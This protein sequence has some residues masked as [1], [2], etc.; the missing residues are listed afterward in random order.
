MR[1]FSCA[2]VAICIIASSASRAD[3]TLR[4]IVLKADVV[5]YYSNRYILT[6]DGHV[7]ARLSDGTVVSGETFAMDLKLNRFIIAG[8]VRLDGPTVH[9]TG[10]AFSG[11]PDLDRFYFLPEGEEPDRWTFFGSDYK[12]THAGR[13]QPGDAFYFPNLDNAAPYLVGD[14]VTIFPKNNIEFGPG[15]RIRIAGVYTP[16]PGWVVNFSSNPNFYQNGFAGAVFDIQVPFRGSANDITAFDIRYDQYQGAFL[17]FEEHLVHNADYLVFTINPLTQD[18]R[19]WNLIAYK[20]ISPAIETRLFTQLSTLSTWPFKEPSQS[21]AYTNFQINSRIGKYAASLN[22]DQYNNSL[23]ETDNSAY[24]AQ[25][26]QVDGHPFDVEFNLQSFEDEW[27]LFRSLGVPLKFQYRAGYGWDYNGYGILAVNGEPTW[28]GALYPLIANTYVG[29]TVYTPSIR[30]ARLTTFSVK[31]DKERQWFSLPHHID[32]TNTTATLAYTPTVSKR[33]AF[34]ASYNVLNI[35]DYYGADQLEAY[36]PGG[37]GCLGAPAPNTCNTITNQY[38]TYTGLDAFRGIATSRGLTGSVIYTP[39]RYVAVNLTMQHFDVSPAPVPG[40]G[41]QAPFQLNAD[42]RARLTPNLLI[43]VSR[44]YYFN[45]GAE[46]WSPEFTVT[47][48]P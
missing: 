34:F 23:I 48:S 15:S 40:V 45:F 25:G 4:S 8:G 11:Y 6:A 24:T 2:I 28:G 20:R 18:Q 26:L 16:T 12:E 35:G 17:A 1:F 3:A 39:T 7:R 44:S 14:A 13:D 19:Q 9:L 21:S 27:R 22:V 30:I 46:R 41:G 32:T 10:A 42:V 37:P 43:D 29:L 38:G 47:L 31:S 33:P 36:P 5:D